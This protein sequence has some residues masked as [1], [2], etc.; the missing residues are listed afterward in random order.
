MRILVF[1]HVDCEHPGSLR[2]FLAEDGIQWDAIYLHRGDKIPSF[3]KYDA[4]WVMGGPMDV[5]DIEENP[6]L[7]AEKAA[8]RQWVS[9]LKKPYLGL[10]L[11]HQLLA[12]ALGG[13]CGPQKGSE[14]GVLEVELTDEGKADALFT[15]TPDT[16]TC[17]QWHSVRVAQAPEGAT[18]L[19]KSD[20]CAIQAM[21]VGSN[22]W[23]MQYHIEIEPDTV[24]NWAAIPAYAEALEDTLGKGAL[25]T[26]KI[27]AE[28]HMDQCL[29]CARQ[30]Y[31]NF[32]RAIA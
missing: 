27:S 19:A 2:Q 24:D 3:D 16:Q 23:S 20:V 5:W 30:V 31:D 32:M 26:L 25:L 29:S 18:V 7:V 6:W 17:L 1:Q 28:K 14:I 10:C 12:D 22:A 11:G 15:G 9:V 8:I 21:R 4:L 13:T